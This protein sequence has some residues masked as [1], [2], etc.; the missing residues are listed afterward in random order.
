MT[1]TIRMVQKQYGSDI[2]GF[3]S[4][5]HEDLPD[6]WKRLKPEGDKTFKTAKVEVDAEVKLRNSARIVQ[7][8]GG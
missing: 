8:N 2:F 1:S 7:E 6:D 3:G 5:I 4:K